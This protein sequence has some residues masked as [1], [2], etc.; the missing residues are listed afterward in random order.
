MRHMFSKEQLI[1]LIQQYAQ[2]I[3][4]EAIEEILSAL[5]SGTL[6]SLIGLDAE[7]GL[8]KQ[9]VMEMLAGKAVRIMPAPTSTTLTAEQI[10]QIHDGA[11]IDGNFLGFYNPIIFPTGEYGDKNYGMI[12]GRTNYGADIK[13]YF[14]GADN[15]ISIYGDSYLHFDM[16]YSKLILYNSELTQGV[17]IK[18]KDLPNYPSSSAIRQFICR[19]GT[20]AWYE[21]VAVTGITSGDDL[22]GVQDDLVNAMKDHLDVEINGFRARYQYE[23]NG[24]VVYSSMSEADSGVNLQVNMISLLIAS[25][26]TISFNQMK[27]APTT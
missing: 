27:F 16:G 4:P 15:V 26:N 6:A 3:T 24:Y 21:P 14:I 23:D 12:M 22:A 7:N 2:E 10:L 11:F 1:K 5:E 17:R 20:L 18:G 9:G 25:P 19:K 8:V 13:V